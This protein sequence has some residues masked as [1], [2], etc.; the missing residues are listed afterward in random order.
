MAAK[1]IYKKIEYLQIYKYIHYITC[2]DLYMCNIK[3][4]IKY[5]NICYWT[6]LYNPH[7][8]GCTDHKETSI[9]VTDMQ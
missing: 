7:K 3:I 8:L 2:V 9:Q 6:V 4:Y 5:K 1:N